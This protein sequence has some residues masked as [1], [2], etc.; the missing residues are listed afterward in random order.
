[1]FAALLGAALVGCA[2]RPPGATAP[3]AAA[4]G[5]AAAGL[6]VGA[7]A[8]PASPPGGAA[9]M[10]ESATAML[11]QPY[12]FG[13]AA[14]GGFD[15]SGLVSFAARSAGLI[16]PRTAHDQLRTGVRVGRR[17]LEAGDLVFMRLAHKQLHVGI[18]IGGGRFIHAPAT[19]GRVRIDSLDSPPYSS[20]FLGARRLAGIGGGAGR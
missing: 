11:G 4:A 18:A 16:V 17:E 12:R 20:G 1:M 6:P 13:G 2:A 5:R 3:A 9:A 8:A 14:P 10:V 7:A 15:C 19:G